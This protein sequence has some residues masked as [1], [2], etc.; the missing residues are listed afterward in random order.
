[1]TSKRDEAP[2]G[3]LVKLTLALEPDAWHG[4]TTET[5][6]V[7][8]VGSGQYRLANVPFFA[9]GLSLRDVVL[10]H[11]EGGRLVFSSALRRGGHSTYR[12]LVKPARQQDFPEF[13]DPLQ[14]SGCTFEQGKG[15]LFAVDVP[16]SANIFDV[17]KLFEAGEKAGVWSFEEGHC[18]H[19]IA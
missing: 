2:P 10:A 8:P 5:L 13:W 3:Q 1:M 18:G 14:A 12:L 19:S 9:F 16:E 11:E 17:Y 4:S 15:N 6:W 7:E